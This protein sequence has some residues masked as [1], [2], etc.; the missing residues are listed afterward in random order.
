MQK[1][2]TLGKKAGVGGFSPSASAGNGA[3][4]WLGPRDRKKNEA[5]KVIRARL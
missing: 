5:I 1:K 4:L 2:R 3:E